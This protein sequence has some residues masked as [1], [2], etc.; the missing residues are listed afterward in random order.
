MHSITQNS[1][2]CSHTLL[3]LLPKKFSK[4]SLHD[5]TAAVHLDK[6]VH[7][8]EDPQIRLLSRKPEKKWR[9][10][11]KHCLEQT[12]LFEGKQVLLFLPRPIRLRG[13]YF[14]GNSWKNYQ[15]RRKE[16]RRKRTVLSTV[17]HVPGED[18]R[19]DSIGRMHLC[20]PSGGAH[21][22]ATRGSA[23]TALAVRSPGARSLCGESAERTSSGKGFSWLSRSRESL[24]IKHAQCQSFAFS[25][26]KKD[27]RVRAGAIGV[28]RGGRVSVLIKP[29]LSFSGPREENLTE[30]FT[31]RTGQ[32]S[33]FL[34]T[35]YLSS[36]ARFSFI[37]AWTI[38]PPSTRRPG[39]R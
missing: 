15:C 12:R 26:Q 35:V 20:V 19:R 14:S 34:N 39:R 7:T 5:S 31:S 24:A 2:Q 30:T 37:I 13:V 8:N 10:T 1:L 18:G 22:E 28:I 9:R 16:S 17:A 38:I 33:E 36:R 11:T 4:N 23:D 32:H 29:V 27:R 3:L 21:Q 25:A 6:L